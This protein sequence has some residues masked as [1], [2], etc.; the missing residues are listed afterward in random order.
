[1]YTDKMAVKIHMISRDMIKSWMPYHV[2]IAQVTPWVDAE[3][4][5]TE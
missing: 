3:P 4:V 2:I 5:G 1:M